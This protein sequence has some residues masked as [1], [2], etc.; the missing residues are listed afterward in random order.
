LTIARP[1]GAFEIDFNG[2]SLW[3][4][5]QT[6]RIPSAQE[7]FQIIDGNMELAGGATNFS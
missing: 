4:K 6:G 2:I 3:S 5:L 1:L 7:L